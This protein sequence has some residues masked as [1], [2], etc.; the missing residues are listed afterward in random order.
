MDHGAGPQTTENIKG[1]LWYMDLEFIRSH[2]PIPEADIYSFGIVLLEVVS[3]KRP[4]MGKKERVNDDIP[5]LMWIWDL[6]VKGSI[7]EAVD[8]R[9]HGDNQQLDHS[10][11][12]QMHHAL[13]I[14]LWCTHPRLEARPSIVQRMNVLQSEDVT[15]PALSW[16]SPASVTT[17]SHAHNTASTS[18]SNA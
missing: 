11:K 18:S 2:H 4:G 12:W 14:G 3:G 7:L 8:E 13:V 5:L 10:C 16:P 17:G 9:L 6:Y 1:T 15:L